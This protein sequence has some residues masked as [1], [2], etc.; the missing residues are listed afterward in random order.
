MLNKVMFVGK[1]F[2]NINTLKRLENGIKY[3]EVYI[4]IPKDVN[5]KVT[6]YNSY[7]IPC[8]I[9]EDTINSIKTSKIQ[10]KKGN[11]LGVYGKL[12][13]TSDKKMIVV[14]DKIEILSEQ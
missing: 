7:L 11:I 4:G 14:V 2:D 13:I 5:K 10:F 6:E 1:L 12:A 9:F 8:L 3:K